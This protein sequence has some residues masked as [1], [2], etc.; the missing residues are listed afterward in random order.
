[1]GYADAL[2][3]R[4]AYLVEL[5]KHV[6]IQEG[7]TYHQA[8]LAAYNK[9]T[10]LPRLHKATGTD[11][12]C[13][14]FLNGIGWELGFRGW[15]WECSCTLIR[16]EAKSRGIW[17]DGW[18][19]ELKPGDW[20]IYN[21][22]GKGGADH[23]GAV[24]SII[25]NAVWVVEGNYDDA[26]KI[27]RLTVGDSRVEGSVALD[28]DELVETPTGSV[29]ALRPG[30]SGERVFLI[31]VMLKGAGFYYGTPNG[32]YDE[33][34]TA[35]VMDFQLLNGLDVDGKAGPQTQGKLRSGDFAIMP[36]ADEEVEAMEEK[37]YQTVDEL[38]EWAKPTITK[39]VKLG[40][41]QGN[42]AGLDLSYDMVR[43]LVVNDRAGLYYGM[44]AELM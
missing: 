12:W 36:I 17:R 38:P 25:G 24:C 10:P 29:A 6:G 43:M 13:A 31:Q 9:I 1:M 35:A 28:F 37:R 5:L 39:L 40:W 15:P 44:I 34:T 33:K 19:G 27:R 4:N 26:V 11:S 41:L 42:G 30:D 8:I 2:S 16:E 20:I 23:I 21:W 7:S 3:A 18:T 32:E 14:I 22:D